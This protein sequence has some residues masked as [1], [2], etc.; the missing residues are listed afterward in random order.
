MR[1][2]VDTSVLLAASGSASGASREIFRLAAKN[3]WTLI[4]T[5]YVVAE[6]R[7]NLSVFPADA[8]SDWGRLSGEL[9]L[10]DDV[11]TVDRPAV[12]TPA[13]DRPVLFGALA[14][15]DVLLTLDRGDFQ[16]FLGAEFY[17][18]AIL[19]PGHFLTREREAKRL[20]VD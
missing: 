9:L 4:A 3:S 13:K 17:G 19:T 12:F 15:A 6:V 7:R 16:T 1:L 18:L 20:K 10:L 5:P 11:F 8:P 14:W 2:F